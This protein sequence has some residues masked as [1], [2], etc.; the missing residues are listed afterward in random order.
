MANAKARNPLLPWYI[1]IVIIA[2]L[3]IWVATQLFSS[4]C[5]A[6]GIIATGVV[7]VIPAVYL[8]LMYL[9]FKSQ[10]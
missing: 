8:V 9:T 1:G 2:V 3:D 10:D 4:A 6:P 7:V 5:Q